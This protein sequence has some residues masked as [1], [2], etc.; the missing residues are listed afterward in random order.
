MLKVREW[1]KGGSDK[2]GSQREDR[3]WWTGHGKLLCAS[4]YARIFTLWWIL[5]AYD[6]CISPCEQHI[7]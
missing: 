4:G 7:W 5:G 2:K 3:L 1:W 6:A